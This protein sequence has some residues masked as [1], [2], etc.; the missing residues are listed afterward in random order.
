MSL[1]TPIPQPAVPNRLI[2]AIVCIALGVGVWFLLHSIGEENV[3]AKTGLFLFILFFLLGA[4]VWVGLALLGVAY[5]G[6]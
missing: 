2:G 5:V 3:W 6:M 1:S 4:G